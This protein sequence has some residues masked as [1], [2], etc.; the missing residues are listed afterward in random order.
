MNSPPSS[1]WTED[2][3]KTVDPERARQ[4]ALSTSL[5]GLDV[6]NF[7]LFQSD[8]IWPFFERLRD[9]APVHYH[10]DS[11]YGP[12]WSVTKHALIKEIDSDH[13]RFSSARNI[14]IQDTQ[15]ANE[16]EP[17]VDASSFIAMDP[18]KHDEQRRVVSPVVAP[19]NLA[20]MEGLIR[21]RVIEILENLPRDEEFNWV[22]RVSIELTTQMLATLFDYPFEERRKLT[23]WSDVAT[24]GPRSGLVS[25][26]EET[27]EALDE[28]LA[29]FQK[30]W[31][32]R[33]NPA[34]EGFDLVTMLAQNPDTRD[35]SP[36][37][38]LSNLMLLIIGGNDT[39]RNS[40]S[41][42]VLA[43]NMFPDQY[44]KL[45]DNPSFIPNMV[46]EI[47]RWQT[48]LAHM[49]RTALVDVD[50]HGQTI[51]KGDKVVMWYVSGNRDK[52]VFENPDKLII[53]RK[54]ARQHVSFGF[55][56]HRCMGNRLA[57][58]QLR[59]LWEEIQKRF[60]KVEVTG[61]PR[62]TLSNFV[63]GYTHL[64]VRVHPL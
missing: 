12:Y 15:V 64:P 19:P 57:E 6:S 53:D 43:L 45:R 38:F 48:P 39:T 33:S 3:Y 26:W 4:Y 40:I 22:D 55:G 56:L 63:K 8:A 41:G 11:R 16:P 46:A 52:E 42:G 59:V 25:S 27:R 62:R 10:K 50:F 17:E 18:P 29:S 37:Q 60:H 24:G 36:A 28:C 13:E 54:N 44:D 61:T 34:H 2:E 20:K 9:E 31:A 1:P 32:E 49:R 5:D 30:L 35:M 7:Y 51:K 58:M 47:I 21:S 14:T 23:F